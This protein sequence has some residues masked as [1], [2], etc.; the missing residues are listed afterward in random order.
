MNKLFLI[1]A[2]LFASCGTFADEFDDLEALLRSNE[3]K[4]GWL[5]SSNKDRRIIFIEMK[6][7]AASD[8][9]TQ[10]QFDEFKPMF[11]EMFRKSLEEK[12]VPAFKKLN[13]TILFN[14]VTT[15]GKLFK[16]VIGPGDL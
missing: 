14:F 11:V 9:M 15:D 5:V 1:A 3:K 6:L 12:N 4:E 7:S 13:I 10:T 16:L 2:L 8:G